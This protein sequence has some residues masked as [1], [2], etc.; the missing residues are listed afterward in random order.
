MYKYTEKEREI[1]E[2]CVTNIKAL[3][4]NL[5]AS[6]EE[7]VNWKELEGLKDDMDTIENR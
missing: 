4:N 2:K 5:V 1:E 7:L 6:F 3:F